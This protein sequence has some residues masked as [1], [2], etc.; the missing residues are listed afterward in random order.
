ML[1]D[2][3]GRRRRAVQATYLTL[4]VLMGGGL[5][6]F[7]VGSGASGGLFDALGGGGGGGGNNLTQ[8]RID[9]NEKR[10][11]VGSVPAMKELVRDYYQQATQKTDASAV[12]F[13][14]EAQGDLRKAG[15]WWQRYVKAVK[16]KPNASLARVA[17]QIF[18]PTALNRPAGGRDAALIVAEATNDPSAYLQV[19]QFAGLA[20]DKR[21]A[22]LAAKKAVD[23][24]PKDQKQAVEQQAKQLEKGQQ[25]TMPSGG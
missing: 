2:L 5:V 25:Q 16:G 23:L 7:G 11:A 15:F 8:K 21:T 12:G 3:R 6:F 4:A 18:D 9:R 17:V 24:A 1:F 19:V 13:P 20:G 10:A 14:K 22:A